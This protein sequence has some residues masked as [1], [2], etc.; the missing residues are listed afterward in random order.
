MT[1]NYAQQVQTL[2]GS[3][4]FEDYKK[5]TAEQ[6]Q[7]IL[8]SGKTRILKDSEKTALCD[9]SVEFFPFCWSVIGRFAATSYNAVEIGS[10]CRIQPIYIACAVHE[11]GLD[12]AFRLFTLK[13]LVGHDRGPDTIVEGGSWHWS[14][15]ELS[16]RLITDTAGL[17]ASQFKLRQALRLGEAQT[18]QNTVATSGNRLLSIIGHKR[19]EVFNDPRKKFSGPEGKKSNHMTVVTPKTE[20]QRLHELAVHPYPIDKTKPTTGHVRKVRGGHCIFLLPN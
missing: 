7:Q 8:S 13:R 11:Y 15:R 19:L 14:R 3:M 4:T 16:R 6:M 1:T 12:W 10:L 2:L 18:L 9:L 17:N 20:R 5:P